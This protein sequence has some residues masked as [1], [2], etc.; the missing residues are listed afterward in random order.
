MR[1]QINTKYR[2]KE[3]LELL[4]HEE[5]KVALEEIPKALKISPRTFLRY[6]YTRV[7]DDYSMPADHLARLARFFKCQIEEMLNYDPQPI[8]AK[9]TNGRGRN[10]LVKKLRLVK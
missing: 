9:E 7:D 6:M 5:Y 4:T 8:T 3:R 2:I 1:Y 10:G